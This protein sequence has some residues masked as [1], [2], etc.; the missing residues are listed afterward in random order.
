MK[1][2]SLPQCAEQIVSLLSG[3][4]LLRYIPNGGTVVLL[5]SVLVTVIAYVCALAAWSYLRENATLTFSPKQLSMDIRETFPWTG[6]IFAGSYAALY[7]RFSAQW[8]YLA[9][10]FNQIS[11]AS[12]TLECEGGLE[13]KDNK[14][15]DAM[16]H[17]KAA[18]IEDAM[19]LHLEKKIAFTNAV[20]QMLANPSVR[21]AFE[22]TV[23]DGDAR[24]EELQAWYVAN[25]HWPTESS[26][27]RSQAPAP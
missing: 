22:S 16:A 4:F 7:S 8:S 23:T 13:G 14:P 6:A 11:A 12:V 24:A 19:N 18:F 26:A 1:C 9:D 2:K 10:L 17:W 20:A 27:S 21:K 3:E 5:R 15:N 25:G